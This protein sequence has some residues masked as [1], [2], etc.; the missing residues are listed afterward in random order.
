MERFLEVEI[1]SDLINK[2]TSRLFTHADWRD[3]VKNAEE[4]RTGIRPDDQTILE[5]ADDIVRVARQVPARYRRILRKPYMVKPTEDEKVYIIRRGREIPGIGRGDGTVKKVWIDGVGEHHH[6][7]VILRVGRSPVIRACMW[8]H[9]KEWQQEWGQQEG[10]LDL[11]WIG[12]GT[13]AFPGNLKWKIGGEV[14]EM[15]A[16]SIKR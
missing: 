2:D 3:F 16:L 4:E 8:R 7:G 12:P 9:I 6:T 1:L 5:R 11:R 10:E 14:E 13:T 15:G